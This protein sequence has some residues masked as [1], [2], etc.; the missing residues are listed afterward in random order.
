MFHVYDKLAI[1]QEEQGNIIM[2][3]QAFKSCK[4]SKQGYSLSHDI[5]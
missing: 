2:L 5:T 4:I 1:V 3:N